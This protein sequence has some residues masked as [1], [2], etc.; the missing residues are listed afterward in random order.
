VN[1]ADQWMRDELLLEHE[2][3]EALTA[4]EKAGLVAEA[5]ILAVACGLLSR[6]KAVTRNRNVAHIEF[7]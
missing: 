4:V 3:I 2:A 5:H 1:E 6:W 7:P